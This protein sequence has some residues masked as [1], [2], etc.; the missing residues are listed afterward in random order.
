[1]LSAALLERWL[2]VC[3]VKITCTKLPTNH[4]VSTTKLSMKCVV[5]WIPLRIRVRSRNTQPHRNFQ[6]IPIQR[7]FD[8][9]HFEVRGKGS[10]IECKCGTIRSVPLNCHRAPSMVDQRWRTA[11]DQRR[12]QRRMLEN[13]I[14]VHP[15]ADLRY[16]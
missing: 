4:F 2:Q 5:N 14:Q 13:I 9:A 1:L 10:P 6:D 16:A 12:V 8:M 15:Y 3:R 11:R 7:S